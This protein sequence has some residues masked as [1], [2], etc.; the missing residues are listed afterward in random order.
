MIATVLWRA[1]GGIEVMAADVR[2]VAGGGDESAAV[3]WMVDKKSV[4][5]DDCYADLKAEITYALKG[6]YVAIPA[7]TAAP[8]GKK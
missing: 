6:K 2:K 3:S 7:A 1:N 5:A 4:Q 8:E